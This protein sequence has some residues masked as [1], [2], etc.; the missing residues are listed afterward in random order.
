MRMLHRIS[1]VSAVGIMLMFLVPAQAQ[2]TFP[3]DSF[4][5]RSPGI[6]RSAD[7]DG[8]GFTDVIS[9]ADS[10]Y[11]QWAKNF[12]DVI[13]ELP[14]STHL[15]TWA[16][17][18]MPGDLDND[19]D[20]DIAV[21]NTYGNDM[22]WLENVNGDGSL[23]VEIDIPIAWTGS[24]PLNVLVEDV[25]A[26][27]DL[28]IVSNMSTTK[29]IWLENSGA[30][31][32]TFTLHTV[33]LT[34]ADVSLY[35]MVDVDDDTDVDLVYYSSTADQLLLREN[36]GAGNFSATASVLITR[37]DVYSF[38]LSDLDL[39]NDMDLL[40]GSK[41]VAGSNE[42]ELFRNDGGIFSLH[43]G[44][45]LADNIVGITTAHFNADLLPDILVMF[46]RDY[47]YGDLPLK[48]IPVFMNAGD[49]SLTGPIIPLAELL[50]MNYCEGLQGVT[51]ADLD[52]NGIDDIVLSTRYMLL[53]V[54]AEDGHPGVFTHFT[55]AFNPRNK[56]FAVLQLESE[57]GGLDKI[58]LLDAEMRL[59]EY[60]L[61]E[62]SIVF[63]QMIDSIGWPKEGIQ[64]ALST[65][66]FDIDND[67]FQ[68][69]LFIAGIKSYS[70]GFGE[71]YHTVYL[72]PMGE[73]PIK[74][75]TEAIYSCYNPILADVNQDGY[76]DII[77]A[78]GKDFFEGYDYDGFEI[79]E[80]HDAYYWL[81]NLLGSGSFYYHD[82]PD[83]YYDDE[84]VPVATDVDEDE[85]EDIVVYNTVTD[86]L[87][88]YYFNSDSE[89][90]SAR[91]VLTT[92]PNAYA[93]TQPYDYDWDGDEDL[94]LYCSG[95]LIKVMIKTAPN[96]YAPPITVCYSV[97][98]RG[99]E[100]FQFADVNADGL[101]D[102]VCGSV[103]T[104]VFLAMD[105]G[106]LY[107]KPFE[108]MFNYTN[109][110]FTDINANGVLEIAGVQASFYAYAKEIQVTEAVPVFAWSAQ[111]MALDEDGLL[112]D[113][114]RVVMQSV[115][116]DTILFSIEAYAIDG[117]EF[118]TQINDGD[119][120]LVLLQ[121]APD[122]T[123]L[124]PQYVVIT[125]VDDNEVDMSESG[126]I[127]YSV[128]TIAGDYPL[129]FSLQRDYAIL[130]NDVAVPDMN[131]IT[132]TCSDT[133]I[134][135]GTYGTSC[136]VQMQDDAEYPVHIYL[137]TDAQLDA[138]NGADDS[139]HIVLTVAEQPKTF[140]V[141]AVMDDI[142]EG[143]HIGTV[144]AVVTSESDNYDSIPDLQRIFAIEEMQ[145]PPID[146]SIQADLEV[147]FIADQQMIQV[148]YD[149]HSTN[150]HLYLTN[151][152]G[153][154]LYQQQLTQ[155]RGAHLIPVNTLPKGHYI[156]SIH[157]QQERFLLSSPVMIY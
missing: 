137:Y 79:Y 151:A 128:N 27:G 76:M 113:T 21:I 134:T 29:I 115:P 59:S 118:E 67:G 6:L 54:F 100:L 87:C 61:S 94:L 16:T 146:S 73:S 136:S 34:P 60:D 80:Q 99:P 140:Y 40:I 62:D 143:D 90:F 2:S 12:G 71:Y 45:D 8:D 13:A 53:S 52:T 89:T 4:L 142:A 47:N 144:I 28:D 123:A 69:D 139:I 86:Q 82:L 25:D 48:D 7:M 121:F 126:R 49:L 117:D 44:Y 77:A 98:I 1:K 149:L 50:P 41:S 11:F 101:E 120:T 152:L 93:Y 84:G 132:I 37:V 129:G 127:L 130:D 102:L 91:T 17:K 155:L 135:E 58:A 156:I 153:Q 131:L 43:S 33:T 22:R 51:I 68:D 150:A 9:M 106:G 46:D 104:Q 133:I 3:I 23:M 83:S 70:D 116:A 157:E 20:M 138:G 119:T 147:Y 107:P 124:E 85:D 74:T 5:N 78:N 31:D 38:H 81:E 18:L 36:L 122:S 96:V 109:R 97:K 30:A 88:A 110:H 56:P 125:A 32:P 35:Q 15:D 39:D 108:F 112:Q 26:D 24:Y 95:D 111:T 114:L 19:G 55:E 57:E 148:D 63:V 103:N 154:I 92:V 75:S 105:G 145:N 66:V 42:F 64:T 10:Y 72:S 14:Y 141:D 65:L